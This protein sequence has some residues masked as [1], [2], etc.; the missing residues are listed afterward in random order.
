[1]L[2]VLVVETIGLLVVEEVVVHIMVVILAELV[3]DLVDLMQVL[4]MDRGERRH[5]QLEERKILVLVVEEE[6]VQKVHQL[7]HMDFLVVPVSFS[8]HT[9]HKYLKNYNV[10]HRRELYNTTRRDFY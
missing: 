4:V 7:V 5:Q 3:E 6:Q 2:L 8:S 1:V 10:C 9:L